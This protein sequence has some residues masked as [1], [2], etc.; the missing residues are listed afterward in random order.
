VSFEEATEYFRKYLEES[1]R[2][3][4]QATPAPSNVVQVRRSL[5]DEL[6]RRRERL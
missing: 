6:R 1:S 4:L 3:I 5:L 2:L